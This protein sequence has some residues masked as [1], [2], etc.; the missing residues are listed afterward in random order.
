FGLGNTGFI[1]GYIYSPGN[2]VPARTYDIL[3]NP[4]A[5][6]AAAASYGDHTTGTGLMMA[7]D[8]ATTPN[9]LVWAQTVTVTPNTTYK[10]S[11]FLSSWTATAPAQL[12]VT[13]NGALLTSATAPSTTGVW[14]EFGG[15]WS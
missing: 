8:G 12:N 11:A 14:A 13:I 4:A 5:A 6:H 7:V 9:V 2:I 15:N 1:S 3:H 10:F